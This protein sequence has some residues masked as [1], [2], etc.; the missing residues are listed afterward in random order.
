[1]AALGFCCDG[2]PASVG[3]DL[4]QLRASLAANAATVAETVI[5]ERH[6][7]RVGREMRYGR[8]GSFA[9][10]VAGPKAGSWFDHELGEGGDLLKL[11]MRER[12][13]SFG[14]AVAFARDLES[15]AP[16][17]RISDPPASPP[18]D[19]GHRIDRALAL[20]QASE[21]T[22]GTPAE[23]YLVSRCLP[24]APSDPANDALRFHPACPFGSG[25]R[26]P[27]M[28]AL[29][30]DIATDEPCGIHRTA[31]SAR[32]EK[33]GRRM[34]GRAGGAAIKLDPDSHVASGLVVGEGIETVLSARRFGLSPA[35]AM[36][37]SGAI[38]A[39]PVLSGIE[40][41]TI[42]SE[43]DDASR[44]AVQQCT[45]RWSAAGREV[46]TIRSRLGNDLNDHLMKIAA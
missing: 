14:T 46:T 22:S 42:L 2:G 33:I 26:L 10:V 24:L 28:V 17:K 5:P 38:A 31:L 37:S 18:E 35:W 45:V 39:M 40:A 43:N 9:L 11:I 21:A 16:L 13:C 36:S 3:L 12:C 44:K 1:M 41:L 20:W 23:R 27:C 4:D 32:G 19:E 30:R 7:V 34:L 15:L 25:K 8:H 29:M 6:G